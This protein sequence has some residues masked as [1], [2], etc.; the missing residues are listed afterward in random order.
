[1]TTVADMAEGKVRGY[2]VMGENPVVGSPNGGYQREGLRNLDW[3]VVRDFTLIET[4]DFW[5]TA[6]EVTRGE[7][8]P[9]EIGTEVF[10]FPAATHTEKDG[11]FTNTQRLLQWHH[12][13]VEPQGDSRSELDFT[14]KLGQRLKKLYENEY[15][16]QRNW[17]IR[18]LKWDYP[19]HGPL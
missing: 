5:R 17:P 16:Q 14:F 4:A 19:T 18:D 12:K 13:A 7:I 9:E 10:F 1:M 11:S 15:E 8:R 2:F 6:P 3:L